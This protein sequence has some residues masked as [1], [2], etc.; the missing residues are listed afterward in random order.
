MSVKDAHPLRAAA[1]TKLA[2]FLYSL[3]RLIWLA[4]ANHASA[5]REVPADYNRA[6]QG[7][8]DVP[9]GSSYSDR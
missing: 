9:N 4:A 5:I 3:P 6:L 8:C 7:T 2:P 1:A